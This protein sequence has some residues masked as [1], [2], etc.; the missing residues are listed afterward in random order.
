MAYMQTKTIQA[1]QVAAEAYAAVLLLF[2]PTEDMLEK[3][4][5][6]TLY[7]NF[8][9]YSSCL[10]KCHINLSDGLS[11]LTRI[12]KMRLVSIGAHFPWIKSQFQA[13]PYV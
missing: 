8:T 10:L 5:T 2:D 7:P 9:V 13:F 11:G 6:T 12:F 3:L 4:S 1:M